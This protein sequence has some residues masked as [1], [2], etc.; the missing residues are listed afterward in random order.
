MRMEHLADSPE[1]ADAAR[2]AVLLRLRTLSET[3]RVSPALEDER[4]ARFFAEAAGGTRPCGCR[5]TRILVGDRLAAAAIDISQ[6]DHRA[7]HMI[8]HD[9]AFD[10]CGPGVTMVGDWVRAGFEDGVAVLDLLAPAHAYKWDWAD[11]SIE[12]ADYAVAT[13]WLG[14]AAVVPYLAH[15]RPRLKDGV[16]RFMQWRAGSNAR[17]DR[18]RA[19]ASESPPEAAG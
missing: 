14:H 16:E 12:V 17:G 18:A 10:A 15:V 8:A 5:V 4:Y 2:A 13:S 6:H 1:A 3:G 11:S 7:T 9:L 19:G